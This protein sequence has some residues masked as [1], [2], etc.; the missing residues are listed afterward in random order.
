MADGFYRL[1]A[2]RVTGS[3]PYPHMGYHPFAARLESSALREK[4]W[5]LQ[6]GH[7]CHAECCGGLGIIAAEYPCAG[8]I[9]ASS[10]A[11]VAIHKQ[12]RHSLILARGA[13]LS[14]RQRPTADNHFRHART[15]ASITAKR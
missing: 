2:V 5:R 4:M 12:L 1:Q 6:C 11:A 13:H 7:K 14:T 8:C 10:S 3:K 15:L 9:D